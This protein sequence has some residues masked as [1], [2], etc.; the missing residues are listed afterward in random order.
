MG[1][2]LRHSAPNYVGALA[3]HKGIFDLLEAWKVL[4]AGP[5]PTL[6]LRLIGEGYP[7]YRRRIEARRDALG[8]TDTVTLIDGVENRR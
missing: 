1:S 7:Y 2:T 6:G 5:G 4:A 8:L 3:P